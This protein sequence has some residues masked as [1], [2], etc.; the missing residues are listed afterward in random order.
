MPPKFELHSWEWPTLPWHHLHIDYAGPVNA[1]CFLVIVDTHSKWVD[2][3]PT[4]GTTAK[5]TI[6]CLKHFL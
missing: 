6:Q 5:E 2:I 4:S 1:R 3:Y